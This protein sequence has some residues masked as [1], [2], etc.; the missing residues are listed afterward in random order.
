MRRPMFGCEHEPRD[1]RTLKFEDYLIVSPR[2]PASCNYGAG[3]NRWPWNGNAKFGDCTIASQAHLVEVF[4]NHTLGSPTLIC[5]D[6]VLRAYREIRPGMIRGI[7]LLR[8]LRHWRDKGFGSCRRHRITSFFTVD[9]DRIKH[10][11]SNIL[12]FGG[13]QMALDLPDAVLST[14]AGTLKGTKRTWRVPP[15]GTSCEQGIPRTTNAHAV[16]VIGW[17][18]NGIFIVSTWN[19]IFYMTPDFVLAYAFDAYSVISPEWAL[20]PATRLHFDFVKLE[21][22]VRRVTA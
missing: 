14:V 8:G 1:P 11:K 6:D 9:Y 2:L 10:V 4:T 12:F 20:I 22:D 21:A 18:P 13:V 15:C 17:L 7:P 5:R 16:A 3:I 19:G